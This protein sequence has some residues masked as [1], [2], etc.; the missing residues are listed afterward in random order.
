MVIV[1]RIDPSVPARDFKI[2]EE[3]ELVGGLASA[4][5]DGESIL[6]AHRHKRFRRKD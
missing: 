1:V 4:Q 6:D 3:V 5:V 2:D